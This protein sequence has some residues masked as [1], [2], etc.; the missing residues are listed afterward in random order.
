M[1]RL[2]SYLNGNKSKWFLTIAFVFS[3][4]SSFG[5]IVLLEN[6][7]SKPTTELVYSVKQKESY[8]SKGNQKAKHQTYSFYK[9]INA[10]Y[11]ER[12]FSLSIQLKLLQLKQHCYRFITPSLF[13][14][15]KTIP[16]SS[17]EEHM[18]C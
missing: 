4:F 10:L 8:S 7:N 14:F 5:N 16:L 18:S 1:K 17:P 6:N 3:L 15:N 2:N 13:V 12:N 9:G 11:F